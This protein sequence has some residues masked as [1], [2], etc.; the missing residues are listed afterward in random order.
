MGKG[1][2]LQILEKPISNSDDKMVN[3]GLIQHLPE[4]AVM[5]YG[6]DFLSK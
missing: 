2:N 6:V 5:A 3:L 1:M 4:L